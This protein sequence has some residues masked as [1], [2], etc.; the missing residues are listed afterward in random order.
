M[1][2][3]AD[4]TQD[5]TGVVVFEL[6]GSCCGLPV[7]AVCRVMKASDVLPLPGAPPLVEGALDFSGNLV[8]VVDLGP[9]LRLS[10]T[11]PARTDNFVLASAGTRLLA[12]RVGRVVRLLY[13]PERELR[14]ATGLAAGAVA[15]K[16]V[17]RLGE[18]LVLIRDL[19]ALL[20]P[21]ELAAIDRALGEAATA[22]P[23]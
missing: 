1:F 22:K 11:P 20:E 13:L 12:L 2:V 14:E 15:V 3:Q 9:R 19:A 10:Q 4:A 6:A 21:S 16:T 7:E 5:V 17:E 18:G 23:S 8:P